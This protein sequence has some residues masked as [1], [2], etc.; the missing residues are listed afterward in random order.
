MKAA[1][2]VFPCRSLNLRTTAQGFSH[3]LSSEYID[4][5]PTLRSVGL[6]D[7]LQLPRPLWS[8]HSFLSSA[9]ETFAGLEERLPEDTP[10]LWW[11]L[12]VQLSTLPGGLCYRGEAE[13]AGPLCWGRG[14]PFYTEAKSL[15]SP[16]SR[17]KLITACWCS[18]LWIL[19]S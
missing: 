17:G 6:K 4:K 5:Q 14:A 8:T 16:A 3:H 15:H 18:L 7:G 10:P 11:L 2:A 1:C 19:V 13:A 12:R 9:S